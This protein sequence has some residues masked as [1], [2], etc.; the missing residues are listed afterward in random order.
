MALAYYE[1]GKGPVVVLIHG[2]CEDKS[3]WSDISGKLSEDYRVVSID[4]PGFG[5][6]ALPKHE[7]ITI[8]EM[9]REVHEL[10]SLL[11]LEQYIIIGHSL[12]GYVGLAYAGLHPERL[13]GLGLFHSSV[14]A[15]P[16]QKKENRDKAIAFV[17]ENGTAPF[18]KGFFG[19]LFAEGNKDRCRDIITKLSEK[20][21]TIDPEGIIMA[22]RAMRDR[23][24][25]VDVLK[26]ATYPVLFI[27][28][29]EDPA[30]DFNTSIKQCQ[31]PADAVIHM[32]DEV[33]HMGMFEQPEATCMA[34]KNFVAY[35]YR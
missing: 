34:V 9:A 35:C 23:E 11:N 15:D 31:L 29:K 26:N 16:Q 17:E 28:G 21:T 3:V 19:G 22:T 12:G 32:Y 20:A 33:G 14:Y 8:N 7:D 10:L 1:E 27:V 5:D 4:L 30:V 18:V 24:E 25:N 6:S 2:F 13:A